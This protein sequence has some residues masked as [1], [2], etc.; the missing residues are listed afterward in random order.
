ME[1]LSTADSIMEWFT[2]QVE[3]K[4]PIDPYQ[5]LEGA[6]KL[7]VLLAVE[8]EKWV[9]KEQEVAQLRKLLIEDGKTVS[10]AKT[11]VEASNEYKDARLLK[12]K[13]EKGNEFIRLV[14]L[15]SRTT[16]DLMRNQM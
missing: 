3:N 10:Y 16:S 15:Y 9:I 7:S 12:G 14:K 8:H 13:L 2:K 11:I 4:Q 5:W 1:N 6:L